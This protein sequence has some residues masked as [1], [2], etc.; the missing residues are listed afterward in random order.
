MTRRATWMRCNRLVATTFWWGVC[1]QEQILTKMPFLDFAGHI[2]CTRGRGAEF[3]SS[4]HGHLMPV[5]YHVAIA[6]GA[7]L[8]LPTS[9]PVA[10][11]AGPVRAPARTSRTALALVS[12]FSGQ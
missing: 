1:G 7:R 3:L 4:F 10:V 2:P 12:P 9:P 8:P 5:G 11:L 6:A